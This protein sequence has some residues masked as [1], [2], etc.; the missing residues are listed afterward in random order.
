M[1]SA[2]PKGQQQ[3]RSRWVH[4]ST[5]I[6]ALDAAPHL[7]FAIIAPIVHVSSLAACRRV[8][9]EQGAQNR[10]F[11]GGGIIGGGVTANAS[12]GGGCGGRWHAGAFGDYTYGASPLL[13][14]SA[15]S[16]WVSWLPDD[17]HTR[18]FR[19]ILDLIVNR[20]RR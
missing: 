16:V 20:C 11:G 5:R 15:C 9:V 7:K 10:F 14:G 6:P 19:L 1:V 13:R 12:A 2:P 3:Q 17:L 18:G 4:S 8:R